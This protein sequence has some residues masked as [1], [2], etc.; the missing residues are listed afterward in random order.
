MIHPTIEVVF[1]DDDELTKNFTWI[2]SKIKKIEAL[3][4]FIKWH[5]DVNEEV[6]REITNTQKIDFSNGQ[7]VKKWATGFLDRYDERIRAMREKSNKIF[8]RYHELKNNQFKQI[9][10]NNSEHEEKMTKMMQVFLNKKEL[11]IGKI[12][13]SFREL[14]FVANHILD[15]TFKLGSISK[16]EEWVAANILNLKKLDTSLKL[17]HAETLKWKE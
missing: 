8:Q 9:I 3:E 5:I 7:D 6:I 16:Y 2:C 10:L 14:W 12:I 1:P 13:F 11:L 17:I 15:S 4:E